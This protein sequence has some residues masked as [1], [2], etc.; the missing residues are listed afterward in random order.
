MRSSSFA[1]Q[2]VLGLTSLAFSFTLPAEEVKKTEGSAPGNKDIPAAVTPSNKTTPAPEIT[3][4]VINNRSYDLKQL[5][6]I[7]DNGMLLGILDVDQVQ[8]TNKLPN[9]SQK[10]AELSKLCQDA[11]YTFD[12]NGTSTTWKLTDVSAVIEASLK[13]GLIVD[14]DLDDLIAVDKKVFLENAAAEKKLT[15]AETAEIETAVDLHNKTIP[16]LFE[17]LVQQLNREACA[18]NKVPE[19]PITEASA[20]VGSLENLKEASVQINGR[21]FSITQLESIIGTGIF[22]G[23]IDKATIDKLNSGD[24]NPATP[25]VEQF[26]TLQ[27]KYDGLAARVSKIS[28]ST[29]FKG[30]PV[31]LSLADVSAIM[32]YTLDEKIRSPFQ[33]EPIRN[34]DKAYLVAKYKNLQKDPARLELAL[35]AAQVK[36]GK[37]NAALGPI[38]EQV[39]EDVEIIK[40]LKQ[41]VSL[42][43]LVEMA[44]NHNASKKD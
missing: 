26:S 44:N 9:P 13:H 10:I 7:L 11:T 40:S 22:M 38:L 32:Q 2:A 31:V 8:T 28:I 24:R 5:G 43:A 19:T 35:K 15:P 1:K 20:F 6:R 39:A 37:I 16:A 3:S 25:E 17:K 27:E 36:N 12:L 42:S 30:A 18:I 21:D 41:P 29:T 23:K 33:F 14:A 4:T 34:I